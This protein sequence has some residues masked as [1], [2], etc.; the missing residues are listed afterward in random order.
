MY[1][2]QVGL[3]PNPNPNPNPNRYI[4]QVGLNP[5]PKH[6]MLDLT[7]TLTLAY[8][9]PTL[10]LNNTG[11]T[12][13]PAPVYRDRPSSDAK[14]NGLQDIFQDHNSSP[15]PSPSPSPSPNPSPSPSPNPNPNPNSN[16]LLKGRESQDCLA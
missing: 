6:Y 14:L 16:D 1:I 5:N 7:R 15:N 2:L 4:L 13:D 3:N 12:E 9:A 10:T 11:W 8:H